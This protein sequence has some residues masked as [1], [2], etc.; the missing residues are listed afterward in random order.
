MAERNRKR[1]RLGPVV[2]ISRGAEDTSAPSEP[3]NRDI[4]LTRQGRR[5][6]QQ[7]TLIPAAAADPQLAGDTSEPTPW[8]PEFFDEV[9][10]D[11]PIPV[12]EDEEDSVVRISFALS[13]IH[14]NLII[15]PRQN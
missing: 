6:A 5:L 7:S 14:H 13:T 2:D 8:S 1:K 12:I 9:H 11:P 3:R 4:T 10:E 15:A